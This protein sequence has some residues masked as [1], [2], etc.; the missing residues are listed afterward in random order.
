MALACKPSDTYTLAMAMAL[1][2]AFALRQCSHLRAVRSPII[3]FAM[4]RDIFLIIMLAKYCSHLVDRGW[5][6]Y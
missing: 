6:Y 1:A 5:R 3:Y 4:A 2:L